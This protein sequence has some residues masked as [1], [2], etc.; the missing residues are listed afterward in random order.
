[1]KLNSMYCSLKVAAISNTQHPD[2]NGFSEKGNHKE[3]QYGTV[4]ITRHHPFL[5][6]RHK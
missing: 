4:F 6:T 2:L 3:L 1:M 5:V